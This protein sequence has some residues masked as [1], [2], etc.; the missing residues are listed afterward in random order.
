MEIKKVIKRHGFT[1]KDVAE[2]IGVS[3]PSLNN[4]IRLQS[5][6]PKVLRKI[7]DVIGADYSEFFEDEVPMREQLQMERE[8]LEVKRLRLQHKMSKSPDMISVSA[9][10]N[11]IEGGIVTLGGRR[12]KQM[13]IPLDE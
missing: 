11:T 10:G 7:A 13:F 4:C 9:L 5:I 1:Q 2:R 8:R 12:Y 3:S 6:S